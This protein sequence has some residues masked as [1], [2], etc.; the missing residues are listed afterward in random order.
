VEIENNAQQLVGIEHYMHMINRHGFHAKLSKDQVQQPNLQNDTEP[1]DIFGDNDQPQV[2][3]SPRTH[4]APPSCLSNYKQPIYSG[5]T[6]NPSIFLAILHIAH[7]NLPSTNLTSALYH[8]PNLH[9]K[10]TLPCLRPSAP[11]NLA[12]SPFLDN[13]STPKK[14]ND[15]DVQIAFLPEFY[16]NSRHALG[17]FEALLCSRG[18]R[19]VGACVFTPCTEGDLR[20]YGLV[21]YLEGRED[22]GIEGMRKVGA[23][24]GC[25]LEGAVVE[26][27]EQWSLVWKV[28]SGVWE[29]RLAKARGELEDG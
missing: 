5:T 16:S 1:P 15:T 21:E 18:H 27:Y 25:W 19:K 12:P 24:A 29:G 4:P 14:P 13:D 10:T 2:P 8:L 11:G 28:V 20:R 7:Q 3:H 17:Y 26:D 22:D 6:H 23:R 9:S